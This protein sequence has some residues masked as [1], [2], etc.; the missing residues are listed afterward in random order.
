MV[1]DVYKFADDLTFHA[2]NQTLRSYL[3][4][5]KMKQIQCFKFEN[6]IKLKDEKYYLIISDP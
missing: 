3:A 2:M 6:Y 4:N 5:Q 1:T